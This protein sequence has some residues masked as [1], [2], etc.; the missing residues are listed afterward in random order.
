[1]PATLTKDG[2][3]LL[4]DLS[5][6]RGSAFMDAKDKIRAVPGRMWDPVNKVW[7]VPADAQTADRILKTIRPDA[8]DDL[9]AWIKESVMHYEESLTAPLPPDCLDPLLIPWAY[10]RCEWQPEVV[11]DEPFD[12]ALP[13]Q[14]A[15]IEKM[16]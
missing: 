11:N 14:R 9:R 10:R 15:A 5:A 12:G 2:D 4:L 13:Y 16:T 7:R 8:G 3:T 6:C 1:M